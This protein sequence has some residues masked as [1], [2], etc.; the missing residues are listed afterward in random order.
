MISLSVTRVCW[1]KIRLSNSP[2][3]TGSTF[4]QDVLMQSP[5]HS[6]FILLFLLCY[7]PLLCRVEVVSCWRA[8]VV[9]FQ[10][11]YHSGVE[12][13]WFSFFFFFPFASDADAGSEL[14]RA[15][16]VQKEK[17]RW[18]QWGDGGGRED[19]E[20]PQMYRGESAVTE[21]QIRYALYMS[22]PLW[23]FI[24]ADV[25]CMCKCDV[26]TQRWK[27]R[28]KWHMLNHRRT[29]NVC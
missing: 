9:S 3:V 6:G 10:L 22:K 15:A 14:Q 23:L 17:K 12:S 19:W 27:V 7:F 5:H 29:S 11:R 2:S 28:N 26:V 8:S 20:N 4:T 18:L 21:Q 16:V 13:M 24:H 25:Y 1:D